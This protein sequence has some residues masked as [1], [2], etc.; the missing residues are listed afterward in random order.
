MLERNENYKTFLSHT[1]V[2]VIFY[3]KQIYVMYAIQCQAHIPRSHVMLSKP[4]HEI[5]LLDG[6]LEEGNV[7]CHDVSILRSPSLT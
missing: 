3:L 5:F 1:N 2:F 7:P 6:S 4:H